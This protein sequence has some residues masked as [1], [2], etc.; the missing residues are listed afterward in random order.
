VGDRALA[1]ELV[2]LAVLEREALRRVVSFGGGVAGRE[3]PGAVLEQE[4]DE[5]AVGLDEHRQGPVGVVADPDVGVPRGDQPAHPFLGLVG[6]ELVACRRR[7]VDAVPAAAAQ[8]EPHLLGNAG[9][10]DRETSA[11]ASPLRW[12]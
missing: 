7:A 9:R 2:D 10:S 11:G 3:A 6:L 1:R 5:G 12:P 4:H 8:R